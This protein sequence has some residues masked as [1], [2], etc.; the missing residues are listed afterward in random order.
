MVDVMSVE[1]RSL[2]MSRIR[3]KNTS[4]E[5][6]VRRLLWRA[7][8]RYR[9][10]AKGLPGKPDIVFARR[11]AAIFVHGCFWHRHDG[12]TLFRLPKTRTSFWDDKL[13][14]NRERDARTVTALVAAGWRVAV[15]WECGVRLDA[16]G[17]VQH[18]G[19]WLEHGTD[20]IELAARTGSVQRSL[21]L[22]QT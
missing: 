15:V 19:R 13:Q 22:A 4:P 5:M 14:R 9:L 8:F 17:V 1:D 21:L 20:S 6:T 12:C 18:L 16:P 7:G 11:R 3:G 2:L 10:H